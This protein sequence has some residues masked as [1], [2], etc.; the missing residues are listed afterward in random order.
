MTEI[1]SVDITTKLAAMAT[2]LGWQKTNFRLVING[3]SSTNPEDRSRRFWDNSSDRKRQK[4]NL[5]N[6][7]PKQNILPAAA[8]VLS[9]GGRQGQIVINEMNIL[10]VMKWPDSVCTDG[11][12]RC[13]LTHTHTHPAALSWVTAGLRYSFIEYA[14]CNTRVQIYNEHTKQ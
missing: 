5:E 8:G 6:K 4:I 10:V 11:I 2:T 3:H 13:L 9:A 7:K 1:S 14:V 12:S